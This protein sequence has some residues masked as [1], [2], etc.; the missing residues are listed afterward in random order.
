MKTIFYSLE[1][2]EET[3]KETV[4]QLK[5][6]NLV[7]FPSDTVYGL[8]VDATNEK[9]VNKLLEFK[10]RPAGKPISVFVNWDLLP[11]TVK[12]DSNL[13]KR[14]EQLLPGPFTIVL[15]SK[16][17]VIKTLESEEH[18]LGVRIPDD[19][20]VAE[21]VKHFKKPIT[22][23]SANLSGRS[24]HYSIPSLL[25]SL[26][27]RKKRLIDFVVDK[28]TLPKKKPSTVVDMTK[29][30]VKILR[31]GDVN[32]KESKSQIST[33]EDE[34]KKIAREL[35]ENI[36]RNKV[37]KSISIILRGDLGSGKTVF[38]KG[39]ADYFGITNII[40]PTYVIEYEYDINKSGLEKL[41]HFDLYTIATSDEYK[42]LGIEKHLE[43]TNLLCF[44]WG[45][46]TGQILELLKKK[47]K[48]IVID[49]D[50]LDERRRKITITQ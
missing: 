39:I 4:D 9:A 31:K 16:N 12:V 49:I 42:H 40:S 38:V 21:L 36:V 41:M 35:I 37:K 43:G 50:H 15:P 44:E 3:V 47:S 7:V 1:T 11:Q 48:L 33:S 25:N 6:G 10:N 23:T 20:L 27:E 5:K 13:R 28:G 8:L 18:T 46:K 32:I 45:E 34:T 19:V 29:S 2:S 24:P 26:S 14:L 22:A 30:R 17:K